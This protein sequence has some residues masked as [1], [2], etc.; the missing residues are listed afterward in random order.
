MRFMQEFGGTIKVGREE[1]FQRW[2][3]DNE[4][5]L[6]AA[7]PEG[8]RYMGTYVTVYSSEKR[9]G[10]WRT[11]VEFDNYGDMDRIAEAS[12]SSNELGRLWQEASAHFDLDLQ[13]PW[14]NGLYKRAVGATIWDPKQK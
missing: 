3:A 2:L 13:A 10:G 12:R 7:Y 1:A 6:A 9:T 8:T 14:H 4:E 5:R 11:F